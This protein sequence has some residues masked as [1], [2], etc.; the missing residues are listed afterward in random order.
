MHPTVLPT[1]KSFSTALDSRVYIGLTLRLLNALPNSN[2]LCRKCL[3]DC[4]RDLVLEHTLQIDSTDLIAAR[5]NNRR[6]F[7]RDGKRRKIHELKFIFGFQGRAQR[8][9][10]LRVAGGA[11]IAISYNSCLPSND[12]FPHKDLL[13]QPAA[14][15]RIGKL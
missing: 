15:F 1:F 10:E 4:L 8:W 11:Q 2:I 3:D 14:E 5:T 6:H 12:F 7:K 9:I 13:Q